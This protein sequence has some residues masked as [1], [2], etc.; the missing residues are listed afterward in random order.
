M[1][2]TSIETILRNRIKFHEEEFEFLMKARETYGLITHHAICKQEL[3]LILSL[4]EDERQ[5]AL[6]ISASKID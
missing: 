3:K 6:D 2:P 1:N 5:K 4:W